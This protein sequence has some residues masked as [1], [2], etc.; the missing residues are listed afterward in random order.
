M[1]LVNELPLTPELEATVLEGRRQIQ[2]ILRGEDPR[3]L[4]ITGPCSIHGEQAARD[5][6][7]R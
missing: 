4:V 7:E 1:D 2:A 3:F 6:A 5:Y